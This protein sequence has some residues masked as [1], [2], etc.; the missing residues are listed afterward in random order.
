MQFLLLYIAIKATLGVEKFLSSA[1]LLFKAGMG[2]KNQKQR[3]NS[4]PPPA[5]KARI[6]VRT[7]S[8]KS[9]FHN[10]YSNKVSSP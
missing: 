10:K 1:K 5:K 8:G 4:P 7:A 3:K 2:K 6:M 9:F